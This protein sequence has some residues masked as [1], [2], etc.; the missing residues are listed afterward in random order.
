MQ[1]RI[2][3]SDIFFLAKIPYFNYQINFQSSHLTKKETEDASKRPLS[4]YMGALNLLIFEIWLLY[5]LVNNENLTILKIL[6]IQ[7][8]AYFPSWKFLKFS[9]FLKFAKLSESLSVLAW[10]FH[11]FWGNFRLFK[12]T[13]NYFILKGGTCLRRSKIK[14][15]SS[16]GQHLER[17]S[18]VEWPIFRNI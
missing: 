3:Y 12:F 16:V 8:S 18:I 4:Y 9:E 17:P 11:S 2:F 13:L 14:W 7:K 15:F 6:K 1:F 5:R 10:F